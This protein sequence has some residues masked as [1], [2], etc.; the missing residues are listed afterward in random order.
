MQSESARMTTAEEAKF[1]INAPNS[2]PRAIKVIALDA[3]SDAVMQ[4]LASAAWEHTR[5]FSLSPRNGGG[6][7]AM[8][9]PPSTSTRCF[10]TRRPAASRICWKA[11]SPD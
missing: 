6:T 7:S 9:S 8:R 4:R 1:R 10:V 5:F 2:K 3:A 11:E